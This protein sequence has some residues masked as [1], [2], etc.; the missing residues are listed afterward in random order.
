[1][2]APCIQG[3]PSAASGEAGTADPLDR[4]EALARVGGKKQ[5]LAELAGML[6]EDCSSWQTELADQLRQANAE[7]LAFTAHL[8]RGSLAALGARP[9]SEAARELEASARAGDLDGVVRAFARLQTA[10]SQLKPVLTAL[11]TAPL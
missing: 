3:N 9:A 1:M 4:T 7:A 2:F 10:L 5:L 11:A 8:M 6:L